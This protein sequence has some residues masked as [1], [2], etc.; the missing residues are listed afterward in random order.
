MGVESRIGAGIHA[1]KDFPGI[2][3]LDT[4][5]GVSRLMDPAV[6]VGRMCDSAPSGVR[7]CTSDISASQEPAA[8]VLFRGVP[9]CRT[10]IPDPPE[11]LF[12]QIRPLSTE[13]FPAR[14]GVCWQGG[15]RDS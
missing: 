14:H 7:S 8:Q 4:P 15:G 5:G 9:G 10:S 12:E 3:F 13:K 1:R 11:A 2:E 6:I